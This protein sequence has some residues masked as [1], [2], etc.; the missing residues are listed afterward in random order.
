VLQLW[1]SE[2]QAASAG[3]LEIQIMA[4]VLRSAAAPQ[5][6][7]EVREGQFDIAFTLAAH[8]PGRFPRLEAFELPF[9]ASRRGTVNA[10]AIQEFAAKHAGPE[11][12]DVQP[13]VIWGEGHGVLHAKKQLATADDLKGARICPP[14]RNCG[15]AL[16]ALGATPVFVQAAQVP[17]ALAQNIVDGCVAPWRLPPPFPCW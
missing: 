6:Y 7:D 11:L 12:S 14:N 10:Q 16:E 4:P 8:N 3:A 1:A 2:V 15:A 13:L 9:V 5:L 17:D